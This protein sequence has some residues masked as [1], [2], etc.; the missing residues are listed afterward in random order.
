M[1]EVVNVYLEKNLFDTVE[2]ERKTLSRSVFLEKVIDENIDTV[3]AD[4]DNIHCLVYINPKLYKKI[5]EKTQGRKVSTYLEKVIK[6]G[7]SANGL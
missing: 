7:V 2:A 1:K 3:E 4:G 6:M 5:L